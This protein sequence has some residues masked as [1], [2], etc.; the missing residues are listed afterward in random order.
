MVAP[1]VNN[2]HEK[3]EAKR[4][5]VNAR[6]MLVAVNA[7]NALMSNS[8][9]MPSALFRD[10]FQQQQLQ[11]HKSSARARAARRKM[12]RVIVYLLVEPTKNETRVQH[13]FNGIFAFMFL[14]YIRYSRRLFSILM[15]SVQLLR[16]IKDRL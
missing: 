2:K 16:R 5:L 4:M 11:L 14:I 10:L 3:S 12:Y 13:I 7:V 9:R 15:F 1:N 6:E 8:I